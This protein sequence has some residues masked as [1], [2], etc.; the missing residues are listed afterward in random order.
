[1]IANGYI[2]G[3]HEKQQEAMHRATGQEEV[4]ISQE[5]V[6]ECEKLKREFGGAKNHTI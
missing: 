2:V 5:L 4:Q 1:M 6:E 3:D